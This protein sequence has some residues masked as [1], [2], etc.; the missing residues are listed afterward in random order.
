MFPLLKNRDLNLKSINHDEEEAS[1]FLHQLLD[2][3]EINL[4]GPHKYI[5]MYA[6][7]DKL[8]TMEAA[9]DVQNYLEENHEIPELRAV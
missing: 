5:K 2:V 8:L 9:K 7:Y 4:T 6:K 3:Y 1:Y